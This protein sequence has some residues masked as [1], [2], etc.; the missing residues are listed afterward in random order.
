MSENTFQNFNNEVYEKIFFQLN[1]L[2][3][4]VARENY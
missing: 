1:F 3:F 4:Q 2:V